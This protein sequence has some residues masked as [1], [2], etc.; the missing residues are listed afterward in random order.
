MNRYTR[1][2]N[3]I[4]VLY[5]T[6]CC[7]HYLFYVLTVLLSSYS[8]KIYKKELKKCAKPLCGNKIRRVIDDISMG[9]PM[10]ANEKIIYEKCI[11]QF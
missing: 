2:G 8:E 10:S 9:W 4:A 7:W 3:I 11:F 1:P 5:N 6:M